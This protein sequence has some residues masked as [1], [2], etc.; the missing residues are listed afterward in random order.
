VAEKPAVGRYWRRGFT[1][2][3]AGALVT[4]LFLGLGGILGWY[5]KF[6]HDRDD[7]RTEHFN[8][9]EQKAA[10]ACDKQVLA[11]KKIKP[12]TA[13]YDDGIKKCM[14]KARETLPSKPDS[15]ALPYRIYALL[16]VLL[17]TGAWFGGRM[18]HKGAA[19][20][21]LA[22]RKGVST[23]RFAV[24]QV[25]D[26][27]NMDDKLRKQGI[28]LK[29]GANAIAE[30]NLTA[31]AGVVAQPGSLAAMDSTIGMQM[32]MID[33]NRSVGGLFERIASGEGLSMVHY[34]NTGNEPAQL[35]LSPEGSRGVLA[36]PLQGNEAFYCKR[37]AFFAAVGDVTVGFERL[38][39]MSLSKF[40]GMFGMQRIEAKDQTPSIALLSTQGLVQ[41]RE[42]AAGASLRIPAK[43][44]V[45]AAGDVTI[46]LWEQPTGMGRLFSGTSAFLTTVTGPGR[47][48]YEVPVTGGTP[49][50]EGGFIKRALDS[51]LPG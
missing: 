9:L 1:N 44:L 18:V 21:Q 15:T 19:Y 38:K 11:N 50:K 49:Q 26:T 24:A 10:V 39:N 31:G 29:N 34:Q 46:G 25:P 41:E 33:S 22:R 40:T 3:G 35:V 20:I 2:I 43:T 45:A 17:L 30:I 47:V 28:V 5:A 14:D 36:L 23:R 37:G 6:S 7:A 48:W 12:D 27:L 13:A 51:M 42:L 4:S 16:G 8:Q 32:R